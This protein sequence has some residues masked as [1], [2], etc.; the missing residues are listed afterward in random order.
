[1]MLES[2]KPASERMYRSGIHC[3]QLVL[4]NE[5]LV[6][7]Y[8]GVIPELARSDQGDPRESRVCV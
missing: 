4:K 1:M 2:D 3:F 5:G 7:I 8:K 6:G